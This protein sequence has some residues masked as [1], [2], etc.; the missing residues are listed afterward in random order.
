MKLL[1]QICME[2]CEYLSFIYV[3]VESY[4]AGCYSGCGIFVSTCF[5][6]WNCLR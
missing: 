1:I 3:L 5:V 6:F 4:R 2:Q